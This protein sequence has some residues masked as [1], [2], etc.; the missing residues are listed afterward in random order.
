MY[1]FELFLIKNKI[2]P[3]SQNHVKRIFDFY[4][5]FF[6][7]GFENKLNKELTKLLKESMYVYFTTS[8]TSVK[9]FFIPKLLS[10]RCL[11]RSTEQRYERKDTGK[12]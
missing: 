7:N 5:H 4:P 1:D 3:S 6:R 10:H 11:A 8:E 12:A 9:L 2:S